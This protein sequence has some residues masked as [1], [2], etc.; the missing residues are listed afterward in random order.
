[1]A[2][3]SVKPDS[4]I[5]ILQNV[6]LDNSYT[7]TLTF[8]SRTEQES[9][10]SGKAF[11]T[12]TDLTPVRLQNAV[13]VPI[14]ADTLYNCNYIMF[15]NANFST[16]WF[17]AF[18]T[19]INYVNINCCEIQYE[20]DVMQTWYFDMD[21][22][23]CFVLREHADSD[24]IGDNIVTENLDLGDYKLSQHTTTGFFVDK[25]MVLVDSRSPNAKMLGGVYN[26][27]HY[28]YYIG[29]Q[30]GFT[31]LAEDL[32]KVINGEDTIIGIAMI[33]YGFVSNETVQSVLESKTFAITTDLYTQNIDGYVPKNKKLF[34]YP[35][36]YMLLENGQ[37]GT[38]EFRLEF[39]STNVCSFK[40]SCTANLQ[41]EAVIVPQNYRGNAN[42][43]HDSLT[44][45]GF[46]QCAWSGD[47]FTAWLAQ[48]SVKLPINTL[49]SALPSLVSGSGVGA[50]SSGLSGIADLAQMSI[51]QPT[52]A[53]GSA[54]VP[55]AQYGM[56]EHA[57]DFHFYNKHI[58]R[59]YAEI[60]DNYF[61]MYGYA[62]RKLKVP[63]ITGRQSWNYV[64]TQNAKVTGKIPFNDLAK[65][66]QILNNGVTFWH[67]DYVGD[68]SRSNNIV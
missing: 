63:N 51:T 52:Q 66:K 13:R 68:Y 59:E 67:G 23:R 17:Y 22:K 50:V 34:T 9:Y 12:Y 18:I 44:L 25:G 1:M 64:K 41:S 60:I 56:E 29:N 47:L 40:V 4:S 37:G 16:K 10:F 28:T 20:L 5:K 24:N 31:Q 55:T 62:T 49:A 54:N 45:S 35:Y 27:L 32:Q 39:F 3:T 19:A 58:T 43:L 21:I 46:P 11:R 61:S 48:N 57:F 36:N 33:P 42:D 53:Y 14:N 65:I 2:V 6:P 38:A 8:S 30:S 7:D 15:Q 26:G